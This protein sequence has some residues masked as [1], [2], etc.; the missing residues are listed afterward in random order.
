ML[1]LLKMSL[2]LSIPTKDKLFLFKKIKIKFYI[3]KPKKYAWLMKYM[4][5]ALHIITKERRQ[6]VLWLKKQ[7]KKTDILNW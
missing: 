4:P 5:I 6:K 2:A 3:G 7:T 1:E